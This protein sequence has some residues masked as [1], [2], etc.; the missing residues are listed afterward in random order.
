MIDHAMLRIQNA[1][2]R[3]KDVM[4]NHILTAQGTKK[5]NIGYEPEKQHLKSKLEEA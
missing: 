3:T 5:D 2:T 1:R 4:L